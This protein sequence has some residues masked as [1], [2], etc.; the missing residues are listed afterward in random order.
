V[1]AVVPRVEPRRKALAAE[2]Q[3]VAHQAAVRRAAAQPVVEQPAAVAP[4]AVCRTP[5][6][7]PLAVVRVVFPLRAV[8]RAAPAGQDLLAA[9]VA[10]G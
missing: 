9:A 10:V 4:R 7:V 3:A 6:A 8:E 2:R 5:G 1:V